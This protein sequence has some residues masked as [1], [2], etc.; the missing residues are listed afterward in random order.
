MSESWIHDLDRKQEAEAEM[1]REE[2]YNRVEVLG[3]LDNI[4]G[5]F[6]ELKLYLKELDDGTHFSSWLDI[7][8]MLESLYKEIE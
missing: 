6:D 8:I 3:Q 1:Q 2:E 7:S 5:H 4:R